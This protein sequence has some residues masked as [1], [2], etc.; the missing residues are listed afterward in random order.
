MI[1]GKRR[2]VCWFESDA[3]KDLD[4]L[5]FLNTKDA[6]REKKERVFDPFREIYDGYSEFESIDDDEDSVW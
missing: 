4:R 6:Q 2:N 5:F 1:N 3:S